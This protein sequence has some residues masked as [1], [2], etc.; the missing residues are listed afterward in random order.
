M[1][2]RLEITPFSQRYATFMAHDDMIQYSGADHV[3]GVLERCGQGTIGLAGLRVAG[4]MVMYL[5]RTRGDPVLQRARV[6][7]HAN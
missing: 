7:T 5:I 1:R 6:K 2:N 3:Q 4:G